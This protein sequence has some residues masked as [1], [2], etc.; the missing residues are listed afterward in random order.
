MSYYRQYL[1]LIAKSM[2]Q[3]HQS[4]IKQF[5]KQFSLDILCDVLKVSN[6]YL[7]GLK[8]PILNLIKTAYIDVNPYMKC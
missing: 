2:K 4:N 1:Y 6:D 8:N 7:H 3:R 5:R